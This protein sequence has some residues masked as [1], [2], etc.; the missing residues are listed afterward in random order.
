VKNWQIGGFVLALALGSAACGRPEEQYQARVR[1]L[2]GLRNDLNAMTQ[3]RDHLR[4]QLTSLQAQNEAMAAQLTRLGANTTE[5]QALLEAARARAAE[6]Q[7]MH[8]EQDRRLAA[9]RAAMARFQAM[10]AAGNLHVRI[11][12]GRM[13]IDLPAGIL[14]QSGDARLRAEGQTVLRQVAQALTQIPDRDFLVAGHTDNQPLR[15]SSQFRDNWELSSQ[16]AVNVARFLQENGV[17]AQHLGAAGYAEF[18]PVEG[19]DNATPE[20]QALNRR[21]EIVL[22]PNI[23]ELPD[24]SSLDTDAPA[25]TPPPAHNP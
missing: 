20:H 6:L 7:R 22:M 23:N 25:T 5:T 11:V 12:R 4:E 16:R 24:L 8:D 19:N 21:V 18:S 2:E 13:V 15:G 1:E 3:E 10:M 9:F 14:F 17:A